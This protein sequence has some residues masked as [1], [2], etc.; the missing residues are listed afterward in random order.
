MESLRSFPFR[1]KSGLAT[2][3]YNY[4]FIPNLYKIF[5]TYFTVSFRTLSVVIDNSCHH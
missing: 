2:N 5:T 4:H 3:E 1:R